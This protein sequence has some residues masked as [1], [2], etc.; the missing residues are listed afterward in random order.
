M[1]PEAGEHEK[2]TGHYVR[3]LSRGLKGRGDICLK[4]WLEGV[5]Q[6]KSK[7]ETA[8]CAG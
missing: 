8:A 1:G 7:R 5:A 3:D 2:G 6:G 4:P